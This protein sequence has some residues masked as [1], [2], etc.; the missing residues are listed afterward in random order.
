MEMAGVPQEYYV[1]DCSQIHL[2]LSTITITLHP[3]SPLQSSQSPLKDRA[4]QSMSATLKYACWRGG[5]VVMTPARLYQLLA[6]EGVTGWVTPN[7][8]PTLPIG[9]HYLGNCVNLLALIVD[10][11]YLISVTLMNRTHFRNLKSL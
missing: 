3:L 6:K 4:R 8:G 7:A 5:C 2:G 10:S 1:N 9:G 11:G